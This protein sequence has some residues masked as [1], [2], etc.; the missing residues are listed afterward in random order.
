MKK[1]I[2]Q[3]RKISTNL[4]L[5]FSFVL[6][7][8]PFNSHGIPKYGPEDKSI[9][10]TLI[11]NHNY[12]QLSGAPDFWSLISF[13]IKQPPQTCQATSVAMVLNAIQAINTSVRD[14]TSENYSPEGLVK[15][16][17]KNG[18]N[19]AKNKTV[20][21]PPLPRFSEIINFAL[22]KYG[23]TGYSAKTYLSD[24]KDFDQ[25][26]RDLL[27]KNESSPSD[28]IITNFLQSDFTNDPDGSGHVSPVGAYDQKSKKVLIL[29]VD[30][31]YY[32]PY[33][34]DESMYLKAMHTKN[35]NESTYRGFVHIY[36]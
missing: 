2:E 22:K 28:F 6:I 25:T 34:V 26:A 12:F 14:S 30:R 23:F 36:K 13:Y 21:C 10:T 29:D 19:I 5:I 9:A 20:E 3:L 17:G 8:I 7:S 16:L 11:Q 31:T 15:D 32:E 1:N 33:W 35:P 24:S 4:I 27:V 18:W